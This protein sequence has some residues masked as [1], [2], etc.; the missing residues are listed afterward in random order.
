MSF[1]RADQAQAGAR[2]CACGSDVRRVVEPRSRSRIHRSPEPL[3]SSIRAT[4]RRS[5]GESAMPVPPSG[6]GIKAEPRTP[7]FQLLVI[8]SVEMPTLNYGEERTDDA[9]SRGCDCGWAKRD[10][11]SPSST[12]PSLHA[13]ACVTGREPVEGER[14]GS[15]SCAPLTQAATPHQPIATCRLHNQGVCDTL[16]NREVAYDIDHRDRPY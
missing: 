10:M 14:P 2:L 12:R 3:P 6:L 4:T 13:S 16:G 11:A 15:S 5:S 1:L 9:S 8:E 7:P